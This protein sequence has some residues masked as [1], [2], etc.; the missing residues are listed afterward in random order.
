MLAP[1]SNAQ[2][3]FKISRT[4]LYFSWNTAHG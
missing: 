1:L 2:V 4:H 3:D